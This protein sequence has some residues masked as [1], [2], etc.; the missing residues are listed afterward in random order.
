MRANKKLSQLLQIGLAWFQLHAG[1]SKPILECPQLE[2]PYLKTGWF[3]SLRTFL[4]SI[5]TK[6]H[7]EPTHI[8]RPLRI[9]DTAIM[10]SFIALH[11]IPPKILY[12]LNLCRIFLQ[13]ECV[14][15][16]SNPTGTHILQEIWHGHRPHD[17]KSA[18]LWPNQACPHEKSWA[19]W[20]TALKD[21]FL[22]LPVIRANKAR[23]SLLLATDAAVISKQSPTRPC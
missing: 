12:H 17:S 20:R 21:A 5:N 15:E 16:I 8:T 23:T 13:V 4:C 18:M 1:I 6:L 22:G 9:H 19:E 2:L 10:E 14:S 3:R 11:T 7:A